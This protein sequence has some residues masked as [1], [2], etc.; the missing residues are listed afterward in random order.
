MEGELIENRD[1]KSIRHSKQEIALSKDPSL[2]DYASY[3]S[4]HRTDALNVS[5]ENKD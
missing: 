5:I 1:C 3:Q 2:L 4:H